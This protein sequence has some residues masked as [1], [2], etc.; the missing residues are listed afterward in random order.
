[1]RCRKASESLLRS[2]FDGSNLDKVPAIMHGRCHEKTAVDAYTAIKSEQG[3]SVEVRECGIVLHTAFRYLGASP[4]RLVLDTSAKP[5]Y[6]LLEVKCPHAAFTMSQTVLQAVTS[7]ADFCYQLND[8]ELCLRKNHAYFYQIQGQM[9]LT[10]TEWCDFFIW[11]GN[12]THLERIYFQED[13]WA[14]DTLPGL[15]L[16]YRLSAIPYLKERGR[17]VPPASF[18]TQRKTA[19]VTKYERILAPSL[20][21]SQ[22]NGRNG[23]NA[24]SVI[25]TLFTRSALAGML[26]DADDRR[27]EELM[28]EAMTA[29]NCLYEANHL[30]ELLAMDDVLALDC[31]SVGVALSGESWVRPTLLADMVALLTPT[32]EAPD[33][34][35]EGVLTIHPVSFS[36]SCNSSFLT[37]FDSHS[38]EH[39]GALI[40]KVPISQAV[41]YLEYFFAHHYPGWGFNHSAGPNVIGHLSLLEAKE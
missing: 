3:N 16:F 15:L 20:C 40:A 7:Q 26:I 17:P 25:A 11:I 29:G 24:C 28:C 36:V 6:G 41:H 2:L 9:A 30:T 1:M 4:D 31:P 32:S 21:Q 37:L 8:G 12:S 39:G 33:H 23:S 22:I 19:Y 34:V 27:T 10:G 38:H 13:I 5:K 18:C 14:R 35:M